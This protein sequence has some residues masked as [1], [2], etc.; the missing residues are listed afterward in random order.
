MPLYGFVSL[1]SF[2]R[3]I[4]HYNFTIIGLYRFL[5]L[6]GYC[7]LLHFLAFLVFVLSGFGSWCF[8]YTK[9]MRKIDERIVIFY[10]KKNKKNMGERHVSFPFCFD[11]HLFRIVSFFKRYTQYTVYSTLCTI[12]RYFLEQMDIGTI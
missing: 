11:L 10:M 7:S 9:K 4:L 3:H 2:C 5:T 12:L 1:V 8:C 6:G